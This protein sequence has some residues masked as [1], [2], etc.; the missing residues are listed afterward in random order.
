MLCLCCALVLALVS[1]LLKRPQERSRDLYRSSQLLLA[2][3]V[4]SYNGTFLVPEGDDVV[5]AEYNE[6]E[7]RLVANAS[8]KKA[9][10]SE[11]LAFFDTHV[12]TR[13]VD[14]KGTLYSFEELEINRDV[15][16]D[17][18]EKEG[19]AHL[20]Y[21]L[22]YIIKSETQFAYVIPIN[23]YGVWDAIY[24][25]MGLSQNGDTVLGM[26]WYKQRETPGLGA[27]IAQEA[28]QK[29]FQG[30]QIFQE[31]EEGIM[32]PKT[33]PLGIKVVKT[34]VAEVYG[35]SPESKSA[36]DGIAGASITVSGVNEAI[37]TS[38]KPYRPFLVNVYQTSRSQ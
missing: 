27:N 30:K 2:A 25:Y 33:A 4:L 34:T 9:R 17:Q 38:L 23:G 3:R 11:I 29:Q 15:Y 21:K 31:K 6:K 13:L 22:V 24:G 28:W 20:K 7:K 37:A 19:Y 18:H 32:N 5:P 12:S 8:A 10:P 36:V 14:S 16:L 26:T 1:Q 35:N